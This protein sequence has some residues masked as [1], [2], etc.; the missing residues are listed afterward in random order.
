MNILNK[1]N[2]TTGYITQE[3]K[4][5]SYIENIKNN[6]DKIKENVV[7]ENKIKAINHRFM[8]KENEKSN[9]IFKIKG[10]SLI[11]KDE[12]NSTFFTNKYSFVNN[13][14]NINQ[15]SKQNS[16]FNNENK[17]IKKPNI[18]YSSS[19]IIILNKNYNGFNNILNGEE[20]KKSFINNKTKEDKKN[21]NQLIETM[22]NYR[23]KRSFIKS[24]SN[25]SLFTKDYSSNNLFNYKNENNKKVNDIQNNK[26]ISIEN[27][28]KKLSGEDTN[29]SIIHRK[30]NNNIIVNSAYYSQKN[31]NFRNNQNQEWDSKKK[32][33]QGEESSRI[34]KYTMSYNQKEYQK[35][36]EINN[37]KNMLATKIINLDK[38][39]KNEK[40]I[41]KGKIIQR[42]YHIKE[43]KSSYDIYKRL[44]RDK[45]NFS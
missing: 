31:I 3:K 6:K 7:K 40:N 41:Q 20:N 14:K 26:K 42:N 29:N 16:L 35:D 37:R 27:N 10:K 28:N 2:T 39:N 23:M 8:M 17:F 21:K 33:I 19:K 4:S 12:N 36:K 1:Y 44:K 25:N 43:S 30:G 22:K 9:E 32:N 34:K 13:S 5:L 38:Y 18:N 45:N 24:S 11:N 15:N